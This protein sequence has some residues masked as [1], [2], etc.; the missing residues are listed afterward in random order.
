MGQVSGLKPR[1]TGNQEFV[2]KM[3]KLGDDWFIDNV[4]AVAR[5]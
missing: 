2:F 1:A 5:H 4:S 3:R